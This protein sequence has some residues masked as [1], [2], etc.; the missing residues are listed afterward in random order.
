MGNKIISIIFSCILVIALC[1][2]CICTSKPVKTQNT[3]IEYAIH[4]STPKPLPTVIPLKDIYDKELTK[5]EYNDLEYEYQS[6][7]ES[8]IIT[9]TIKNKSKKNIIASSINFSLYN[10]NMEL[11]DYKWAYQGIIDP[12]DTWH[13][14]C[15]ID[16]NDVTNYKFSHI[17]QIII[18]NN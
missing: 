15:K 1:I 2:F 5:L 4:T 13:F 18:N 17:D 14:T 10:K 16:N 6:N 11:I 9:G 8:R 12:D 3:K 7:S